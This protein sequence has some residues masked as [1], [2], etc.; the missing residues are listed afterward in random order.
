MGGA[1]DSGLT[2]D[3]KIEKLKAAGSTA[4]ANLPEGQTY[5]QLTGANQHAIDDAY[6]QLL[7]AESQ[8]DVEKA[9][10]QKKEVQA[11]ADKHD[12]VETVEEKTENLG[13]KKDGKGKSKKRSLFGRSDK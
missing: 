8:K 7:K 9:E 1:L 10:E 13:D 2:G 12:G 6:N 4:V 11:E 5:A 3:E